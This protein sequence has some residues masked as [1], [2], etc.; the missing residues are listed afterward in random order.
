MGETQPDTRRDNIKSIKVRIDKV[1][2]A[3]G[4][5]SIFNKSFKN[6][7]IILIVY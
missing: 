7:K 2:N 1:R 6:S 4:E 5:V 3:I